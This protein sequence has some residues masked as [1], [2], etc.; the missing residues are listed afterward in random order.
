M[1]PFRARRSTVDALKR[2]RAPPARGDTGGTKILR[3]APVSKEAVGGVSLRSKGRPREPVPQGSVLGPIL[4]DIGYDWVLRGRLLPGMGVIC[5]ADDTL[6]YSRGRNYKEAARL[7]EVGLDLVISRIENLGLRVRIDK[8]EAL[9]FRGTGRKGPPPG[10]TLQIGEGRVKMSSQMKYL[11][12]IL[13]G[14]WTFGPHFAMVGPKV[15]KAAS[16]LGRLLPNLGGPSAACRQLYSGVCRSMATYGALVWADRLTVKN[17]AAL[18]AA[19]RIIAVRVIRGYR[20]VSWAAATAL[21]GDPPWKLVAEV[22][23]E[24]YSYVS[25][26][27]EAW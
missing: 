25:G 16:A 23:A 17:K 1:R 13:D 27:R 21:A 15:V 2:L 20:T 11:G 6:V 14:G 4:W 26:R 10:A 22:L 18:R 24:T 19:Q 12:L 5:Y 7:A 9:L 3:S 8:T